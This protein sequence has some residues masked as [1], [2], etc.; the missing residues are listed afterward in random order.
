[1]T[2]HDDRFCAIESADELDDAG[3]RQMYA[4]WDAARAEGGLPRAA[5]LRPAALPPR[6]LPYVAVLGVQDGPDGTE[7]VFRLAGS[8]VREATGVE[9]TDV[10]VDDAR[11]PADAPASVVGARARID[12]CIETGKPYCACGWTG[13]SEKDYVAH[14]LLALPYAD[15]GGRVRRI[16]YLMQFGIGEAGCGTCPLD[17]LTDGCPRKRAALAA[18]RTAAHR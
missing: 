14:R 6:L 10:R 13:W 16:V 2:A 1:M 12:W 4:A 11:F 7:L 9:I 18:A 5:D 15:D 3:F 17:E 8:A